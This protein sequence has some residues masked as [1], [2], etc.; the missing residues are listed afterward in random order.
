MERWIGAS[1]EPPIVMRNLI[2]CKRS[3][4]QQFALID[5]LPS[6]V[7]GC[8]DNLTL[9]HGGSGLTSSMQLSPEI[10][11]MS[12]IVP[13]LNLLLVEHKSSRVDGSRKLS[14]QLDEFL[15][16]AYRINNHIASL[17]TYLRST[18]ASYLSTT[19]PPRR[20][21]P[22]RNSSFN[23]S[24]PQ[25]SGSERKYLTDQERTSIDEESKTI[26]RGLSASIQNLSQ[27]E[28]I[29]Q[30]TERSVARKRRNPYGALGKWAS[31]GL[32][33]EAEARSPEEIEDEAKAE[34]TKVH[35]ESVLGYLSGKL[36]E[37]N[38]L[39]MEMIETRI[40]RNLEKNKSVLHKMKGSAAAV[41]AA[42]G[43]GGRSG[44]DDMEHLTN[45]M[46][47]VRLNG[48]A[49]TAS[50]AAHIDDDERRAIEAQLSPEQL[51]L[52]EQEN[53]D[54]LKYYENTLDQ[55]R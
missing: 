10:F 41:A 44:D 6:L 45:G 24:R 55:V 37:C 28:R 30:D 34:G 32:P 13:I 17:R 53:Q 9:I 27:A 35:R 23:P 39:L 48:S 33:G 26:L 50:K 36:Q 21:A 15:K 3:Q 1:L 20:K 12:N 4:V 46:G 38:E 2:G 49:A 54:M 18:R 5:H 11:T 43:G 8:Q 16:E 19:A 52:F 47:D 7:S 31:G 22:S 29:R 25:H 14:A 51:Q 42:G 40:H